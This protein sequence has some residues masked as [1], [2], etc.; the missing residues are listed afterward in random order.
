MRV[1]LLCLLSSC[2]GF[3]Q[4]LV[5]HYDYKSLL[6]TPED[7]TR[8]YS[9]TFKDGKSYFEEIKHTDKDSI[10]I[11][12]LP[13]EIKDIVIADLT[14]M[15]V[16]PYYYKD[17]K[18]DSLLTI[19]NRHQV[20]DRLIDW[21]WQITEEVKEIQGM[22]CS[23]AVS[24]FMGYPFVAWFTIEIPVNIGPEYY[25]GLPGLILWANNEYFEYQAT[26]IEFPEDL[27]DIQKPVKAAGP[28]YTF[29]QAQDL[30]LKP[31]KSRPI[32]TFKVNDNTTIQTSIITRVKK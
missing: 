11:E 5:V 32:R 31:S 29:L 18:N 26:L 2:F 24:D 17:F 19:I 13:K 4:N 3:A 30:I 1:L 10:F 21:D 7:E 6:A 8:K 12:T 15:S 23:K 16:K 22:L 14:N 28:T 9:L 20:V 27:E 25:H